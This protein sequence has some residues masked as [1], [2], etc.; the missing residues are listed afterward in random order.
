VDAIYAST[1]L[2][3]AST[4]AQLRIRVGDMQ[5]TFTNITKSEVNTFTAPWNGHTGRVEVALLDNTGK[6]LMKKHGEVPISNDIK[7]YNFSKSLSSIFLCLHVPKAHQYFIRLRGR[8]LEQKRIWYSPC[9]ASAT[10]GSYR[11]ISVYLS[12]RHL[13]GVLS[14]KSVVISLQNFPQQFEL[15]IKNQMVEHGFWKPLVTY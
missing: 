13:S 6:E 2:T 3:A 1:Y 10:K 11:P 12:S 5:Q 8:C 4:A 9:P 14:L 15:L 7:T